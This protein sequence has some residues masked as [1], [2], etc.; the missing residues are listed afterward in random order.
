VSLG[1]APMLPAFSTKVRFFPP[2]PD[3]ARFMAGFSLIEFETPEGETIYDAVLPEW[4]TLRFFNGL[5]PET[6]V[7]GGDR[8]TNARFLVT[9]PSGR[10]LHFRQGTTRVWSAS[11]L[12]LGWAQLMTV[13]AADFANRALD[14]SAHPAFV[15]FTPLLADLHQQPP[16]PEA[17]FNRFVAFLRARCKEPP[18]DHRRIEAFNL[19]LL[20]P[21]VISVTQL[22][23]RIGAS[24]RTID[25]IA[26]RAFGFAPK[27]LLRR[28]RL[29]RSLAQFILDPSLKWIGS[30]D[31]QYNDQAQF[32]RDFHY[33]IG[34]APRKY[35]DMPHPLVMP[36]I[37]ARAEALSVPMQ[38]LTVPQVPSQTLRPS[39]RV[40]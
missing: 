35:A 38:T 40:S 29:M 32:I 26:D 21:D 25:R 1:P 9:G 36:Y 34:M 16:D 24:H 12:P 2:P 18:A 28:Q 13:P 20:D 8:V 19:A 11:L 5:A 23:E 39:G 33:F 30:I 10:C 37:R 3:L 7:E 6:W 4:G 27:V 14:G 22:V 17:E 15:Q 31:S